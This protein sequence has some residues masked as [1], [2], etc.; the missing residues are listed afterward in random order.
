MFPFDGFAQGGPG[1]WPAGRLAIDLL[2][3]LRPV[4]G[5]KEI[6]LR[7]VPRSQLEA[8]LA[9][10]SFI[11]VT[12]SVPVPSASLREGCLVARVPG[13]FHAGDRAAPLR[14]ALQGERWS[15][16]IDIVHTHNPNLEPAPC[17]LWLVLGLHADAPAP[18]SLRLGFPA[19]RVGADGQAPSD[20]T[21][22]QP[23]AE[24]FQIDFR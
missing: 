6:R 13:D 5:A 21:P 24:S 23:G 14:M 12:A 1:R 7:V 4:S 17:D 18:R 22:V 11:G 16:D 20:G 3:L 10:A 15:V 8:V 19:R 9:S 2:A